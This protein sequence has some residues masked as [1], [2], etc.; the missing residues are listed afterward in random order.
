MR[1][2]A[3]VRSG[4]PANPDALR[5]ERD[6]KE[7][8]HL[9]AAG[10]KGEPPEWPL[11]PDVTLQAQLESLREQEAQHQEDWGQASGKAA[12]GIGKKLTAV[13]EKIAV[14]EQR[15]AIGTAQETSMWER[16]WR[17]P[18]ALVWEADGMADIAALYVRTYIE[19]S[20]VGA[21][22]AK[23]ALAK[24]LAESLLLTTAALHAARFVIDPDADD[25][26]PARTMAG[27]GTGAA[28]RGGL[29][30]VDPEEGN[31]DE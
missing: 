20:Q 1:G 11:P 12:V 19:A 23:V 25:V 3:R 16:L 13:A 7:W 21:P 15:I 10:R 30:V 17:T 24:Q 18:Q 9:P 27:R 2:G 14:M 31:D 29:K 8:T 26:P 22:S 28:R 6:G 4:P 5:R